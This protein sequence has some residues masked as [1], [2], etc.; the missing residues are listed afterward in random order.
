MKRLFIT[1]I[2]GC[3]GHY[4]ADELIHR[5]DYE[6][7][8]LVRDPAKLN[9]DVQARPNIHLVAGDL[10]GIE[11]Q[12]DLLKTIDCAILIATSWGDPQES[13]EINVVK[14][15]TLLSL[16]D[17]DRCEQVI[18][19][20]TASIL[21]RHGEALPEAGSLGT[22]YVRTKYLCHQALEANAPAPKNAPAIQMAIANKITAVYPT[23]V[24]GG[25]TGKPY[26]HLSG[27]LG[28]ILKW[29]PLIRWF[30]ADASFH[31]IHAKDIARVV[32]YYVDHVP[33][34]RT[35][36][37]L[38][39][40][41]ITATGVIQAIC[42]HYQQRIYVQIPLSIALANLFIKLFR[43][44]MAPWDKFCLDYRHFTYPNPVSP[45]QLGLPAHCQTVSELLR[46]SGINPD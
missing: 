33:H 3:I 34:Q 42:A 13:Y 38:G 31:F 35:D 29:L 14:T 19:F 20:S 22:D 40:A 30:K 6:L 21:N 15:L 17:P 39:N 27:G 26:S 43:L 10:T 41:P 5:S 25:E 24:F 32:A 18:Y 16:L 45:A 46:V 23:L 44:K 8:L 36:I 4:L 11:A 28:D 37:V 12:A 1:G 7:F 9:F 2:S